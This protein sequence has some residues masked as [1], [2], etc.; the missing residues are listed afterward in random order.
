M[1]TLM[2]RDGNWRP[3]LLLLLIPFLTTGCIEIITDSGNAWVPCVYVFDIT[4][5]PMYLQLAD[6]QACGEARANARKQMAARPELQCSEQ[7]TFFN[8]GNRQGDSCQYTCVVSY[9]CRNLLDQ[10]Y[11]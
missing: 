2:N 8:I 7:N 10:V 6:R 5:D 1:K 4:A 9:E 3:L 11:V